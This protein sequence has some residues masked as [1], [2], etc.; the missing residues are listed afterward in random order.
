[1]ITLYNLCPLLLHYG[2]SLILETT[3]SWYQLS[4]QWAWPQPWPSDSP[5]TR[6]HPVSTKS[7][8]IVGDFSTLP[9]LY[10][11]QICEMSWKI[12]SKIQTWTTTCYKHEKVSKYLTIS[13][14]PMYCQCLPTVILL[15]CFWCPI[16]I[17]L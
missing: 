7:T 4:F 15:P 13:P 9:F 1:M 17:F 14:N 8:E 12:T 5:F 11:W 2:L 3:L 16:H 6:T 10:L